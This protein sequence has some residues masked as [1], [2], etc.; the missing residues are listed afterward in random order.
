VNTRVLLLAAVAAFWCRPAAAQDVVGFRSPSG[1]IHCQL[2]TG[3]YDPTMRCDVAQI[4][5][6][7]PPRPSSCDLEWGRAFEVASRSP[8]GTRLCYGDTVQDPRLP[9]LNYGQ[10]FSREGITCI[11]SPAGVTCRN[12]GG[13]G[14]ELARGSQRV[15]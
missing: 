11:S 3:N 2:F 4:S 6:A 13:H 5:N 7:P 1:N 8:R 10:S 15:F 9:I 14:F 12:S